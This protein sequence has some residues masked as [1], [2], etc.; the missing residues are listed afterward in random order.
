MIVDVSI[1]ADRVLRVVCRLAFRRYNATVA[2]FIDVCVA[3]LNNI[4]IY[5][6]YMCVS[7]TAISF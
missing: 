7:F 2:F 4:Y 5:S 1:F 3:V 6:C